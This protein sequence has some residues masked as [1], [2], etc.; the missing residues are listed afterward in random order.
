[1][2]AINFSTLLSINFDANWMHHYLLG[3]KFMWPKVRYSKVQAHLAI[4]FV[5]SVNFLADLMNFEIVEA[6]L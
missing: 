2:L 3:N 4:A 6:K 1:M 5:N